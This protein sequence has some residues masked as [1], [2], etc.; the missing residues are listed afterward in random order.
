MET[1]E[2]QNGR[3]AGFA[4][5]ANIGYNLYEVNLEGEVYRCARSRTSM[6]YKAER[7]SRNRWKIYTRDSSGK[8]IE[9]VM[10]TD[11]LVGCAWCNVD[12]KV[13]ENSTYTDVIRR[14][15][16]F[17]SIPNGDIEKTD[18]KTS[19]GFYYYVTKFGEVWN[20]EK[21]TK[22]NGCVYSKGYRYVRL[23]SVDRIA[24]HR[25]VAQHFIPKPK[26]LS[27]ENLEVNHIDGNK[28]NNRSDNLEWVTHAGNLAHASSTGL[29]PTTIDDQLLE[30][31]FKRLQEG[32]PDIDISKETGISV[33]TINSIRHRTRPRYRTDKYTWP[34]HSTGNR[35][36]DEDTIF[37]IYDK[38][39]YTNMSDREIARKYNVSYQLIYAL[40]VGRAHSN[41]ACEYIKS[42]GL[43]RYWKRY[44]PAK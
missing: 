2:R 4:S 37:S 43:D 33:T 9:Q 7:V 28:L 10:R 20:T 13:W 36:L 30:H 27:E 29:I 16:E 12:E 17:F 40:R 3:I 42:K 23:G 31:I 38:F 5:L 41:L 11:V 44:N 26:D 15:K 18:Y 34:K 6:R 35:V 8:L 39:M 25:L 14:C 22:I 24:M 32:W 21:M 1:L 19:D